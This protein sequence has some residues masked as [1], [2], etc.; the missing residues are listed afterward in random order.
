M[1]E[2]TGMNLNLL[3]ALDALLQEASVTRAGRRLTLDEFVALEHVQDALSDPRDPSGYS[4]H[5]VL[6]MGFLHTPKFTE[7]L[8]NTSRLAAVNLA[9]YDALFVAGGQGPMFTFRT[10]ESLRAAILTFYQSGRITAALC[11]GT[12]A[13]LDVTMPNGELLIKGKFMTGFA[14]S[15]EDYADYIVGR[16]LMPFRIQDEAVQRGANFVAAPAFSPYAVRDGNLI[17]GQQQNSAR[18]A[19]KLIIEALGR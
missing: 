10:D 13:L 1:V 18:A 14:N 3:V 16:K 7:L 11:H 15:E 4:A 6:S 5:D 9:D 8:Q 2:L 17:T 12:C 19:A